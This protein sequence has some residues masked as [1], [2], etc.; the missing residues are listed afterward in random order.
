MKF[1]RQLSWLGA[2]LLVAACNTMS[3]DYDQN[4]AQNLPAVSEGV[5]SGSAIP[6]AQA[7]A[8]ADC[9]KNPE[10]HDANG[11]LCQEALVYVA[12]D[13]YDL[14]NPLDETDRNRTVRSQ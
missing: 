1:R 6:V 7:P 5:G 10:G 11:R 13:R 12:F 14:L 9:A 2:A 4:K 8:A 3:V